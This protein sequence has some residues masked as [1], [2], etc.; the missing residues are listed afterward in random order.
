MGIPHKSHFGGLY[1]ETK[2]VQIPWL[3]W[4][5]KQV[6]KVILIMTC[7]PNYGAPKMPLTHKFRGHIRQTSPSPPYTALMERSWV[8]NVR[9]G[10]NKGFCAHVRWHFPSSRLLFYHGVESK[11]CCLLPHLWLP[12]PVT[13]WWTLCLIKTGPSTCSHFLPRHC[14]LQPDQSIVTHSLKPD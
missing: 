12:R 5:C 10:A 9:Y 7:W 13:H 6:F 4:R 11:H 8:A 1:R 3:T 2:Q 14:M